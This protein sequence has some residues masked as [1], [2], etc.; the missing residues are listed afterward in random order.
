MGMTS[1]IV[2]PMKERKMSAIS[3]KRKK[4]KQEEEEASPV[5]LS[6]E[7]KGSTRYGIFKRKGSVSV[8]NVVPSNLKQA[9]TSFFESRGTANPRF[10]YEDSQ[11]A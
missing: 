2:F 6:V 8:F 9:E 4:K 10:I 7:L 11:M 1:G 5:R 3:L